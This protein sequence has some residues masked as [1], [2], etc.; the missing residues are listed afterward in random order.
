MLVAIDNN[1]YEM[2]KKSFKNL[3]KIVEAKKK[4]S[5]SIYCLVSSKFAMF[6]NENFETKDELLRN[7]AEYASLGRKVLYTTEEV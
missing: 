7:V 2:N 6:I 5:Y 1:V 4:G 3:A